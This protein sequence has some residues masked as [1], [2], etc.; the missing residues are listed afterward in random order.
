[1][2]IK[3]VVTIVLLVVGVLGVKLR[4]HEKFNPMFMEFVLLFCSEFGLGPHVVH[5]LSTRSPVGD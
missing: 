3:V 4:L 1:M 2:I 5:R